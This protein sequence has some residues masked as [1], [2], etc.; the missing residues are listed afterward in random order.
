[1]IA[2]KARPSLNDVD[3]SLTSTFEYDDVT[4]WHQISNARIPLRW[5]GILE[6]NEKSIFNNFLLIE[7]A[8]YYTGKEPYRPTQKAEQH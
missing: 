1:M 2:Q 3:R 4:R 8:L 7:Q 5:T 6:N